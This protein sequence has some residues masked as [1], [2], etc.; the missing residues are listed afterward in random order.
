MR[1]HAKSFVGVENQTKQSFKDECDVNRIVNQFTKTGIVNH[2]ARG[3]P[4]YGDMPDMDFHE[5]A[6]IAAEVASKSAEGVFEENT[7]SG[8]TEPPTA[9]EEPVTAPETPETPAEESP[10]EGT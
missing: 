10:E 8:T 1:P 5:S 4:Q 7:D 6:C 9:P 2:L 3:K